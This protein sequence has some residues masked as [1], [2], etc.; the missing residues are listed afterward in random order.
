RW[1]L[2]RQTGSVM[3]ELGRVA[4]KRVET[5]AGPVLY[6]E[7]EECRRRALAMDLPLK[8]IYAA[9]SRCRTSEF[10]PEES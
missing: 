8:N 2:P 5:P 9:V 3:T 6:P 1:T 10:N 4:V 7:Y